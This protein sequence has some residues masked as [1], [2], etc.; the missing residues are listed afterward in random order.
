VEKLKRIVKL[1][2]RKGLKSELP[3]LDEG[4][5]GLATDTQEIFIGTKEGNNQLAKQ[6]DIEGVNELLAQNTKFEGQ[7]D[8]CAR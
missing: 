4:E 5:F 3:S 2:T 7:A 8:F 1:I 6:E